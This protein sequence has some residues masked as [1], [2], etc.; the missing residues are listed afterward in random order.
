MTTLEGFYIIS[1]EVVA[2]QPDMIQ[3]IEAMSHV[4]RFQPLLTINSLAELCIRGEDP[5]E[6]DYDA[7]W[8]QCPLLCNRECLIYEA[9]PFACRCMYKI[10]CNNRINSD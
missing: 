7:S 2:R 3:K 6:E 1:H 9:R 8:G 4:R 10:S 5:P